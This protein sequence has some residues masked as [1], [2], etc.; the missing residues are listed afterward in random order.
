[1]KTYP[2]FANLVDVFQGDGWFQWSRWRKVKGRW[3]QV[4]GTEVKV[5]VLI[6]KELTHGS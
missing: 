4:G 3:F 2:I 5:P 1:M 6:I